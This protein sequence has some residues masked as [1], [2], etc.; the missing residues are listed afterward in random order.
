MRVLMIEKLFAPHRGG[1]EI[2][3]A[4]LSKYLTRRGHQVEVLTSRYSQ[5]LS[6]RSDLEGFVVTRVSNVGEALFH[7]VLSDADV[8][9][10]HDYATALTVVGAMARLIKPRPL[11]WTPHGIYPLRT[12]WARLGRIVF[13]CTVGRLILMASDAVIALTEPSRKQLETMGVDSSKITVIPNGIDFERL[14]SAETC[15]FRAKL[16]WGH[17]AILYIGRLDWNKGLAFAVEAL[18]IVVTRFPDCKLV[19]V[20]KDHGIASLLR[21][22]ARDLGIGPNLV[23]AGEMPDDAIASLYGVGCF[24]PAFALRRIAYGSTGGYG[25]RSPRDCYED[26]SARCYP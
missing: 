22:R 23:V 18:R 17:P 5:E 7:A 3:V 8:V 24:R 14:H 15:G 6:P 25:I 19:L 12:G 16:E 20:G 4:G 13:D 21:L 1:I 2:H 9:H 26:G 11:V 10:V